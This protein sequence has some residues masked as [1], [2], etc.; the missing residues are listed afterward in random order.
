MEIDLVA[1]Y[2]DNRVKWNVSS[3]VTTHHILFLITRGK[4]YY[5]VDDR[6]VEVNKGEGLFIPQG[7]MRS[8]QKDE[9]EPL[10]I[11]SVHF[12]NVNPEDIAS[13]TGIPYT[14]IR[15]FSFDYLKQRYSMLHECW[16]GKMPNY[17]LIARGISYEILGVVQRELTG[18]AH[19]ASRRNLALRIQQYILQHFREQLKLDELAHAV[20]R[21]PTYVSTVFREVTGKTPIEYMHEVRITAARE[22]LLTSN[23]TIREIAETLGYCDQTYFNFM[24]KKIVGFP[25]SHM[26]KVQQK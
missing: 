23:M 5:Q 11:Y 13:F 15:P 26:F 4:A 24:Y 17:E 21:S 2:Q 16:M 10:N 9:R 18:G 22:L 25:P 7:A 3:R 20:D 8:A 12:R 1:Y 14:M 19:S 6:E